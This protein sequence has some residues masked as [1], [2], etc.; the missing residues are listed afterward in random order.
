MDTDDTVKQ[1]GQQ[2]LPI[3][4]IIPNLITMM[5][6]ISG[7]TSVQKAMTGDFE[8]AVMLLI[9]AGI[10]DAM[11]GAIARALKEIGRAHV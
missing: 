5:A 1:N 7:I 8:T 4:K 9:V 10:F 11:D 2:P 6:L 3:S